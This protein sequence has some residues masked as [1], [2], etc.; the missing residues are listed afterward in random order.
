M[1]C[2][3]EKGTLSNFSS[4]QKIL[5]ASSSLVPGNCRR[6]NEEK[7]AGRIG[8][9]FYIQYTSFPMCIALFLSLFLE[10]YILK[11]DV[12]TIEQ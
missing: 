9:H 11:F 7:R 10:N 2:L 5:A 1:N 4:S 12:N 6:E 8:L 3:K